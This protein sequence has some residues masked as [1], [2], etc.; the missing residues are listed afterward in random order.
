MNKKI[1][2]F[3]ILLAFILV[4]NSI[5]FIGCNDSPATPSE[6]VSF[7]RDILPIFAANCSFPGCHNSVDRQAGMDLASWQSKC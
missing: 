7:S 2:L 5:N 6:T 4:I 1:F 3:T